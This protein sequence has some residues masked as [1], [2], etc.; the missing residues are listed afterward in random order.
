MRWFTVIYIDDLSIRKCLDSIIFL[1]NPEEKESAHVTIRG[2]YEEPGHT[3]EFERAIRG[4]MISVM[5]AGCFFE[6]KQSTVFLH[7][8]SDFLRRVWDKPKTAF[9]PHITLYDGQSRLFADQLLWTIKQHKFYFRIRAGEVARIKSI[10][11]QRSLSLAM[12]VDLN[13]LNEQTGAH[14]T[15]EGVRRAPDWQR[16]MWIDRVCS[17]LSWLVREQRSMQVALS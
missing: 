3:K 6:G 7:C 9:A 2:P 1:A 15:L 12:A 17:H 8:G 10:K 4:K 13:C 11:G 5:G 16:L 14:L